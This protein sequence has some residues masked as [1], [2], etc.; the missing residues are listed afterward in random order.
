M[1]MRHCFKFVANSIERSRREKSHKDWIRFH[2]TQ[3]RLS[4]ILT[5]T[6]DVTMKRSST[7]GRLSSLIRISHG[8]TCGLGTFIWKQECIS[9]QLMS[10]KQQLSCRQVTPGQLPRWAMLTPWQGSETKL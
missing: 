9:R 6:R 3:S 7:S 4:A 5:T 2:Q 8:V 10:S 1:R